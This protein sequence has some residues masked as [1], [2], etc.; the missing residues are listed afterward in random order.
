MY[1]FGQ[2]TCPRSMTASERIIS[3]PLHLRL[4]FDQVEYICSNL[5]TDC[6]ESVNMPKRQLP[7]IEDEDIIFA[8]S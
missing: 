1:A 5:K 7:R 6:V 8:P 3:L 2:E 4:T